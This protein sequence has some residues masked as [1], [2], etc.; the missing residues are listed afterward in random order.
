M[1]KVMTLCMVVTD[2]KVLLGLKKRGFGAGRWN[3][4]GGKLEGDETL[5]EAAKRELRE[6]VGIETN[7]LDKVGTLNFSFESDSALLLEVHVFRTDTFVGEPL[8]SEE[9]RP[10]WFEFK[11]IP[12]AEMWPDDSLWLPLVLKGKRVIGSFHFDAP[13]SLNHQAIS[14]AHEVKEVADFT[15]SV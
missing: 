10:A 9:M 3:G 14:L 13:A 12:Y 6:E 4:F 7:T 8:E 1:K 5:L 15:D 11:E 2:E